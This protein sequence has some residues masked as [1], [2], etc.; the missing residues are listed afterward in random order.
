MT[1]R[2]RVYKSYWWETKIITEPAPTET[3]FLVYLT[4]PYHKSA[5]LL[6]IY[7]RCNMID[8]N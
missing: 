7:Y 5:H 2:G 3:R 8:I 4:E 1:T 6:T